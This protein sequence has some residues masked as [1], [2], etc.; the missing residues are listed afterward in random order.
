MVYLTCAGPLNL[1]GRAVQVAEKEGQ[2][3]ELAQRCDI[4]E[5][6]LAPLDADKAEL[7]GKLQG[8]E[9]RLKETDKARADFEW[10]SR[11]VAACAL[12]QSVYTSFSLDMVGDGVVGHGS[13]QTGFWTA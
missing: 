6:R 1:K 3:R 5:A 9:R 13:M 8:I 11:R 2:R 12:H 7:Q 10:R 4:L